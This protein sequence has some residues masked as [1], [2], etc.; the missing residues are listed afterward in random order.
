ML[1]RKF[2]WVANPR[3]VLATGL[4]SLAI[5][6]AL[7]LPFL[8][9]FNL[10]E[11]RV[12]PSSLK[13]ERRILRE[14]GI[15]LA[16]GVSL[17]GTPQL[18]ADGN[19]ALLILR[20]KD[21]SILALWEQ[22][23]GV[24]YLVE[25]SVLIGEPAFAATGTVALFFSAEPTHA[26][27]PQLNLWEEGYGVKALSTGTFRGDWR[28]S[29]AANAGRALLTPANEGSEYLPTIDEK[30]PLKEA[31]L[32]NLASRDEPDRFPARLPGVTPQITLTPAGAWA[33]GAT[34]APIGDTA[35]TVEKVGP[36]V[37]EVRRQRLLGKAFVRDD[38]DHDG[39]ADL[40]TFLP[41]PDAPLWRGYMTSGFEGP[42][43]EVSGVTRLMVAY[44]V[45]DPTGIPVPGDYN[46]DGALDFAS[47]IPGGVELYHG[48]KYSYSWRVFFSDPR[49]T[50]Q[51]RNT[52]NA[53]TV[54]AWDWNNFGDRATP[55]DFDGDGATDIASFSP[56]TGNWSVMF[57]SGN[58]NVAKAQRGMPGYGLKF[59]FGVIGD[60][61]VVGDYDGDGKADAAVWRKRPGEKTFWV[62]RRSS[63][64][65][66]EE[67]QIRTID[68]G[69]ETDI[70]VPGNFSCDGKTI[71]ALYR[72]N[73][74]KWFIRYGKDRV[75]EIPWSVAG[76][77]PLVGDYDGDGCDDLAFF[78]PNGVF[79][80][81]IRSSRFQRTASDV[82]P[83]HEPL[84]FRFAWGN[85]KELPAQLLLRQH[86]FGLR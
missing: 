56:P 52:T 53:A 41:L 80:W 5:T 81:E 4:L 25:N 35:S 22:G 77:E 66:G 11:Q 40:L 3:R 75:E 48:G 68:F 67:S 84:I 16:D 20:K 72:P 50:D 29:I 34:L 28:I 14:A 76:G 55:A 43:N 12:L 85:P 69:R 65:D 39:A 58:F 61:P 13:V 86:Q 82:F 24:S 71:P 46:G 63:K 83:Q 36:R 49:L 2:Q 74:G 59:Q 10:N 21:R 15:T 30:A 7:V 26:A 73:T 57:S 44:R 38:L 79:H 32:L 9:R 1:K 6:L 31:L 60:V 37:F 78:S 54:Q 51:A 23:A 45:G 19:R 8:G 47:F 42:T 70:P 17:V 62:I 18:S 64:A 27:L 33:N